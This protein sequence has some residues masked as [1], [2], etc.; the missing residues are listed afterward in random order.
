MET[1]CRLVPEDVS[2]WGNLDPVH[3]LYQGT[4]DDVRAA[5]AKVLETVRAAGRTRCVLSSGC[6]LAPDTPAENVHAL[7]RSVH[8]ARET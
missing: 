6:T 2:L 4:A 7:I 8:N 1:A 3:L 5:C